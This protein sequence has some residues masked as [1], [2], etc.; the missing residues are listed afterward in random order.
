MDSLISKTREKLIA[1]K[2]GILSTENLVAWC[3][4]EISRME[5][6]PFF[7]IEISM[8]KKPREPDQ[9][10]LVKNNANES[11][12]AGLI[13]IIT[14]QFGNGELMLVDLHEVC[15]KLALIS[16]GDLSQKLHWVADEADLIDQGIKPSSTNEILNVLHD[17]SS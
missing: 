12:C 1:N 3:D 4:G 16:N 17:L 9:L 8:G 13:E 11:D 7:L 14:S 10:D 5:Q 2:I 15:Y 6:P